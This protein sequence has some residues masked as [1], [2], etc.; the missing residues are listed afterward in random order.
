MADPEYSSTLRTLFVHELQD[1]KE[2]V[3]DCFNRD[4]PQVRGRYVA[5]NS[6][7]LVHYGQAVEPLQTHL[8]EGL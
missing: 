6:V 3:F 5:S 8:L 4:T 7:L 2:Q 1:R